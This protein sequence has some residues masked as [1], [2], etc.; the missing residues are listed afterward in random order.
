MNNRKLSIIVM[1]YKKLDSHSK[2]REYMWF[3]VQKN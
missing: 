2:K 1:S 3:I